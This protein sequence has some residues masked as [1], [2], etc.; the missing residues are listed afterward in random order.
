M[1]KFQ[2]RIQKI[3]KSHENA[4]VIGDAFGNLEDLLNIYRTVFVLGGVRPEIK[5][6]NLVYKESYQNLNNIT[7]VSAIFFNLIDL[8]KLEEFKHFW[9]KNDSVVIIE[10][11]EP[12]SRE[13]SKPLYSTGWGC[14]SL[15]GSFHVWEKIK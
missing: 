9:Q 6:K 13:F 1:N 4:V 8:D 15:Q 3:S 2:K 12:I 5:S 7:L 10:G 14:T 11:E